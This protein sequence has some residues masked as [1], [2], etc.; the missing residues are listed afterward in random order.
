MRDL[1]E[2]LENLGDNEHPPAWRPEVGDILIFR[3]LR[4]ERAVTRKGVRFVAVGED[5][6]TGA[7]VTAP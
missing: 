5:E 7:L 6:E 3:F 1:R 4:Y 2:E